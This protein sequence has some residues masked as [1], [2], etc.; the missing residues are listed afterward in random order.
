MKRIGRSP[1]YG[2]AL[3]LALLDSPKLAELKRTHRITEYDPLVNMER[4]LNRAR[5][6]ADH[7]PYA[8]IRQ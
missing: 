7:D 2:S 3:C 5:N 8:A 6:Q 1:D 4:D